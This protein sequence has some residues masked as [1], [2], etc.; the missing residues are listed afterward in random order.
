MFHN[1][2][3]VAAE[4]VGFRFEADF[5]WPFVIGN[6]EMSHCRKMVVAGTVGF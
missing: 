6:I 4:S 1:M 2:K 5:V 3:M